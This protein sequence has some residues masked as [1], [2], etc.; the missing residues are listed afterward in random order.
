[1]ARAEGLA[2][3]NGDAIRRI[4]TEYDRLQNRIDAMY[5]DKLDGRIDSYF[6][7][8]R[9]RSGATSSRSAWH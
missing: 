1:M 8:A 3:R 2:F 4:R 6:L 9:Q 5:I 7:I